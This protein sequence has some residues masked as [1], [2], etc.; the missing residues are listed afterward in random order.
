MLSRDV[1]ALLTGL[2]LMGDSVTPAG[3][4]RRTRRAP[5]VPSFF[6]L[7]TLK[8]PDMRFRVPILVPLFVLED[9]L[10]SAAIIISVFGFLFPSARRK[11]RLD[12]EQF[13]SSFHFS[14]ELDMI[15]ALDLG[16]ELVKELRSY[17]RFTLLEVSEGSQGMN[18]T[19]RFI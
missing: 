18:L 8:L 14:E 10:E 17:G 9:L 6:L 19:L 7:F 5:G 16:S 2:T 1:V 15:T 3:P 12:T 13:K 4:R 11:I